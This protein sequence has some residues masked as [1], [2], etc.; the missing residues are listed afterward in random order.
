MEPACTK[1]QNK[2]I[3]QSKYKKP[4][5]IIKSVRLVDPYKQV[6]MLIVLIYKFDKIITGLHQSI[7]TKKQVLKVVEGER[8]S[9]TYLIQ[10][11]NSYLV[12]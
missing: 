5:N 11:M 8:S 7:G 12:K 10:S 4:Y 2:F 1:C 6:Y 3:P 9:I